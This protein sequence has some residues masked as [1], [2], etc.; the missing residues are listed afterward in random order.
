KAQGQLRMQRKGDGQSK[1]VALASRGKGIGKGETQSPD[2]T[3]AQEEL[4]EKTEIGGEKR[5]EEGEGQDGDGGG[6][7][8]GLSGEGKDGKNGQNGE[9]ADGEGEAEMLYEIYK[10]QQM[11]R[12]ALQKRLQKEG[13]GGAGQN[14]NQQMQDIEKQLLN[15]RFDNTVL[16]KMQN[17]K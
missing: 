9:G 8:G 3:Q 16:Q 5:N 6:E 11:L 4:M 7:Q 13:L 10:K 1:G 2:T 12:D 14:A 17:L 15:K